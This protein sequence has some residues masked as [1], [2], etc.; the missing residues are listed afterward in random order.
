MYVPHGCAIEYVHIQGV[1]GWSERAQLE[2]L[3][4]ARV[5]ESGVCVDESVNMDGIMELVEMG[6]CRGRVC[7]LA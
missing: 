6:R 3:P 7:L 4:R 1:E 5:G 2:P